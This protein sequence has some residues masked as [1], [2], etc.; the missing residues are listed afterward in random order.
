MLYTT[1][2]ESGSAMSAH[3]DYYNSSLTAALFFSNSVINL[4]FCIFH[5]FES[6]SV[7]AIVVEQNEKNNELYIFLFVSQTIQLFK[8]LQQL[9]EPIIFVYLVRIFKWKCILTLKLFINI[10]K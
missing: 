10:N 4:V 6:Y 3:D 1:E 9:Y 7:F 8:R 2:S 5:S